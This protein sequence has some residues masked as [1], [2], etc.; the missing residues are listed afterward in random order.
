[1]H[2]TP[3]DFGCFTFEGGCSAVVDSLFI[4]API[5]C[6]VLCWSLFCYAAL[7]ALSIFV[8][9][10]TSTRYQPTEERFRS[11]SSKSLRSDLTP[12]NY[13]AINRDWVYYQS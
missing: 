5:V 1:M 7:S 12:Y 2:L 6:G 11:G 9:L 3:S 4:V 13:R 10:L 8:I